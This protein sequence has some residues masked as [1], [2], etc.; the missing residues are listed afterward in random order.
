MT[1]YAEILGRKS[2]FSMGN[3]FVEEP[4]SCAH[5]TTIHFFICIQD[6]FHNNSAPL[7]IIYKEKRN[8]DY[9]LVRIINTE[10]CHAVSLSHR[11]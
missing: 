3:V 5:M 11:C 6:S 2:C 8:L 10:L 7:N 9:N 4:N 1:P